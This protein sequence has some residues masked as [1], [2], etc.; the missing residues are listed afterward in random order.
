VIVRFGVATAAR[1]RA[2]PQASLSFG[3]LSMTILVGDTVQD[4]AFMLIDGMLQTLMPPD[5]SDT[6][7]AESRGRGLVAARSCDHA[8]HG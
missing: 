4:R 5:G 7:L 6:S 3:I 2:P 8:Q 1:D